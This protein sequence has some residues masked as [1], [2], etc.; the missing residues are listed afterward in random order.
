MDSGVLLMDSEV[1][2]MDSGVVL[3]TADLSD[4]VHVMV[5]VSSPLAVRGGRAAAAAKSL[6]HDGESGNEDQQLLV[7]IGVRGAGLHR[8]KA[9]QVEPLLLCEGVKKHQ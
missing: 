6:D 3:K 7:I 8:A 9:P 4:D 5:I 2:L 1:P